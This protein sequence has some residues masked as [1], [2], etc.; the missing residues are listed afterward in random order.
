MILSCI[1]FNVKIVRL[2]YDYIMLHNGNL[3]LLFMMP[4]QK[5]SAS[6]CRLHYFIYVHK[7]GNVANT[8]STLILSSPNGCG[9]DSIRNSSVR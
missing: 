4:R 2:C 5:F 1:K 7:K 6:I 9:Y 8:I 3:E